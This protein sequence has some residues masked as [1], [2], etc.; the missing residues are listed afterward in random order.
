MS[1]LP[2]D[3]VVGDL[4]VS[5]SQLQRSVLVAQRRNLLLQAVLHR[6]GFGLGL[7]VLCLSRLGQ[8]R[9]LQTRARKVS[10]PSIPPPRIQDPRPSLGAFSPAAPTPRRPF[11][12]RS[13]AHGSTSETRPAH[14]LAARTGSCSMRLPL[15]RMLWPANRSATGRLRSW[16]TWPELMRRPKSTGS[17]MRFADLTD[18]SRRG[19]VVIASSAPS[20]IREPRRTDA[21]GLRRC[22][23]SEACCQHVG[24]S[25]L[26]DA[27]CSTR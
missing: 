5:Q 9:S 14:V 3:I 16:W 19:T 4:D 10:S 18:P 25:L 17:K 21:S 7:L 11:R 26:S 24:L 23:V 13:P 2:L 6:V 27:K 22:W 1:G 15:R 8:R 20:K 12:V